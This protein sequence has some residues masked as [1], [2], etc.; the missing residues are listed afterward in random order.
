MQVLTQ[1]G[2]QF[3]AVWREVDEERAVREDAV[4]EAAVYCEGGRIDY[5]YILTFFL[6]IL[7]LC[8]LG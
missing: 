5:V 3:E 4:C 1:L 8:T 2:A 6:Q 7:H